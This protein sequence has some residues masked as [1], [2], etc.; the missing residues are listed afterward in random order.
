MPYTKQG[1]WNPNDWFTPAQATAMDQGIYDAFTKI[2]IVMV[3]MNQVKK[4]YADQKIYESDLTEH[5][6]NNNTWHDVYT[7]IVLDESV[8]AG[9]ETGK[10]YECKFSA[11]LKVIVSGSSRESH[12]QLL[13]NGAAVS[14]TDI[15]N[16]TATYVWKVSSTFFLYKGDV[17]KAQHRYTYDLGSAQM[18]GWRI[19]LKTDYGFIEITPA[20]QGFATLKCIQVLLNQNDQVRITMMD[21]TTKTYTNS[22]AALLVPPIEENNLP[23]NILPIQLKK[24]EGLAG[25]PMVIIYDGG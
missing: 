16:T 3:T 1:P 9:I 13:R 5:S 24:I 14:G 18:A 6:C 12:A 25:S 11:Q 15:Y 8:W 20:N 7:Q 21:D 17:L 23:K 19:L 10:K 4:D 2:P 22:V